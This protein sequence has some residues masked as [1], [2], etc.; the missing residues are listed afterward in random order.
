M[1]FYVITADD[2]S[3]IIGD[4]NADSIIERFQARAD[5][6]ISWTRHMSGA[7]NPHTLDW[8]RA[9][10]SSGETDCIIQEIGRKEFLG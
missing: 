1:I 8:D 6:P 10:W 5:H 9:Y 7:W 2:G 3:V 4:M